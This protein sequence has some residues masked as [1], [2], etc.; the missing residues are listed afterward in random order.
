MAR[1][2][3]IK[4]EFF[5]SEDIVALSPLARL[6]YIALWCEADKEGRL[7]WKPLTFKLRYLPGDSCDV[8]ALTDELLAR[9]LVVLY[10]DGLAYIPMFRAHQH[11]NPREAE[12]RYPAPG[13]RDDSPDLDP[14]PVGDNASAREGWPDSDSAVQGSDASARVND[15]SARVADASARV[16]HAQGG[17][18]GKG[19]ERKGIPNLT[20]GKAARAARTPDPPTPSDDPPEPVDQARKPNATAPPC[21]DGVAP[22]VWADWLA[23]RRAKRAPIT[24]TVLDGAVREAGKAGI[25]LDAFLR[26]WV[27]R[28]STGLRAEWLQQGAR[29][30]P[31]SVESFREREQ[32]AARERWEGLTGRRHPDLAPR[33]QTGDVIDLQETAKRIAS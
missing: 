2:R 24:Q 19:R 20:V 32:R 28:G 6:L 3:T 21:P 15:A 27:E 26:E 17:R 30:G 10:G 12:S 31:V 13:G 4:P 14:D 33:Q 25:P 9:G 22:Q 5:T 7:P 23:L 11:I 1:I 8:A 16:P 29:R 18:E